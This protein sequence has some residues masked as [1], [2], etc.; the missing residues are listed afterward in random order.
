M[1]TK[2]RISHPQVPEPPLQTWSNGLVV[3]NQVFIAGMISQVGDEIVGGDSMYGQAQAI[4]TKI[5]HLMESVGGQMDDIVKVVIYVTDIT[6]REEVWQARR[7]VF[8]GDF[9][10]STLVEVAAL[11]RPE[12]L[13]EIEAI[14]I[15]GCAP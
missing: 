12:I 1:T 3:G 5:K 15:L 2:K 11:A 13:V 4:F 6:R 7:E 9:P 14:A 8:S 10:V